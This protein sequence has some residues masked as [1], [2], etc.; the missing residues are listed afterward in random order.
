MPYKGLG[1]RW[2]HDAEP[3]AGVVLT[4]DREIQEIVEE[5]MDAKVPR[6]AVVV[7]EPETGQVL[8]MASRPS[9]SPNNVSSAFKQPL[10]PMINLSLIHI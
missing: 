2:L 9:F 5:V 4:I 3:K 8:A 6:G 1:I 7:M 10:S